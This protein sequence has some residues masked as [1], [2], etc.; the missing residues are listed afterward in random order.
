MGFKL[1]E[2]Q[3]IGEILYPNKKGFLV[4]AIGDNTKIQKNWQQPLLLCIREIQK[5]LPNLIHSIYVRG[6]VARGV[7][8][9][10]LSDIDLVIITKN[11][12]VSFNKD[13]QR[14]F[15]R[16]LRKRYKQ[17]DDV[18]FD[19][20][21]YTKIMNFN[22]P[23]GIRV[24]LTLQSKCILGEDLIEKFPIL[25]TDNS[26]FVHIPFFHGFQ[27]QI[28][29]TIKTK[30]VFLPAYIPWVTK[31]YI[32]TGFELCIEREKVFTR[33]LYPCY[34]IFTKYYPLHKQQMYKI[35]EQC[36]KPTWSKNELLY[37]I[38]HFG[39]WLSKEISKFYPEYPH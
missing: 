26:A 5:H 27:D 1:P 3:P 10:G 32:R 29:N 18:E 8:L 12:L 6:S 14:K 38:N 28:T 7:A 19:L 36:I 33:D 21:P 15:V 31:R 39:E 30:E 25:K 13:W 37:C 24:L 17:V 34:E 2:I 4:S 20:V 22:S 23:S 35:L 11:P 9:S 16:E